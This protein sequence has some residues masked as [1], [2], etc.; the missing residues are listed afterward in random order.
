MF[1][2]RVGQS[3][4]PY[5]AVFLAFSLVAPSLMLSACMSSEK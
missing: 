5:R 2:S 3:K 4:A 1:F